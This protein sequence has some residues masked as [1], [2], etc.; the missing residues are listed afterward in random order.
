MSCHSIATSCEATA[1]KESLLILNPSGPLGTACYARVNFVLSVQTVISGPGT[2]A[3]TD[4]RTLPR[5]YSGPSFLF[6]CI[7]PTSKTRKKEKK[8]IPDR[9]LNWTLGCVL[10]WQALKS[11]CSPRGVR[12]RGRKYHKRRPCLLTWLA[13]THLFTFDWPHLNFAGG[14]P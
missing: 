3:Q 11:S 1:N 14:W 9:Q 2:E 5:S 4:A 7:I 6:H 13:Q 10:P 8:K 12:K